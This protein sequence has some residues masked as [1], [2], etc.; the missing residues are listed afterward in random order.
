MKFKILKELSHIGGAD[1]IGNAITAF[2]WLYLSSQ[3]SPEEYG[4]IFY[5]IGI[6]A[7]VSA[8]VLI[9]SQNTVIVYSSK[10]IKISSTLYFISLVLSAIASLAMMVYFYKL[11]AILLL[12]GYVINTLAIGELLGKKLFSSYSTQMLLQKGLTLALG[13]L[14]FVLFG[15]DGIL[16]ALALSYV[17]FIIII[18]RVF[19]ET[20]IDFNLLK[21]RY[22]FIINN[23][24][25]DVLT[26]LNSNLNR[27]LIVPLLGLAILG[28]FSLALQVVN[29][30]MIFTMIVFKYTISSDSQGHEN[31]KLK[32]ITI[33]ISVVVALLVAFVGPL[34]I[35]VFFSQY[36]EAIAAIRILSFSLIP[37]TVTTMFTSKL[38]GQEK[39]KQIVL[40]KIVSIIIFALVTVA[41][42]SQYGITGLAIGY[43]SATIA[44]CACLIPKLQN[45]GQ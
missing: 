11:D 30:G 12:F 5:Y 40:S 7:T 26:K 41:L 13:L 36:T 45:T 44:E 8:F 1:I 29:L 35:P 15:S 25:I 16:F 34:I 27:F 33:A 22:V 3:I 23:Y 24:I 19:R 42:S 43:L 31:K 37:M 28:N 9:G 38:L 17:F 21:T 10:N 6:V 4:E 20:K 39:S 18:V 2:F 14:F 32:K